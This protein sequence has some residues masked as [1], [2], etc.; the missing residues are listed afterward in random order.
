VVHQSTEEIGYWPQD[1]VSAYAC[2]LDELA[3]LRTSTFLVGAPG[4]GKTVLVQ[5]MAATRQFVEVER[6]ARREEN[7]EKEGLPMP[8]AQGPGKVV[9]LPVNALTLTELYGTPDESQDNDD[10]DHKHGKKSKKHGDDDSSV[11]LVPAGAKDGASTGGGGDDSASVVTAASTQKKAP[12]PKAKRLEP[13]DPGM[14]SKVLREISLA[15]KKNGRPTMLVLDGDCASGGGWAEVMVGLLD[16]ADARPEAPPRMAFLDNLSLRLPSNLNLVLEVSQLRSATPA[17]VSRCGLLFVD[18]SDGFAWRCCMANWVKALPDEVYS[19]V[20]KEW[21]S[22]FLEAYVP[23]CLRWTQKARAT[24]A[25]WGSGGGSYACHPTAMALVNGLLR[26]LG[27]LIDEHPQMLRKQNH[28][29]V[30]FM[31]CCCWAMGG[32]LPRAGSDL[33][34]G[35]GAF[36]A[37][38]GKSRGGGGGAGGGSSGGPNGTYTASAFSEW[39]RNEF[40][41]TV[42][43]RGG[44]IFD[45]WLDPTTVTFS[46]WS[47]SAYVLEPFTAL[48]DDFDPRARHYGT[49]SEVV[50]PTGDGAATAYWLRRLLRAK[51]PVLVASGPGGASGKRR[52]FTEAFQLMS[53]PALTAADLALG[54]AAL[55]T[56]VKLLRA[57]SPPKWSTCTVPLHGSISVSGL[58]AQVRSSLFLSGPGSLT[59][60]IG[61]ENV[62]VFVED[63]SLASCGS[64]AVLRRLAETSQVFGE[65]PQLHSL[66][67]S[68]VA[69]AATTSLRTTPSGAWGPTSGT[70]GG[71][72]ISSRGHLLAPGLGVGDSGLGLGDRG[73]AA[74]EAARLQRHFTIL[75]KGPPGPA[76]LQR[77]CQ[78]LLVLHVT[79]NADFPRLLKD[80]AEPLAKIIVAT[81]LELCAKLRRTPNKPFLSFNLRSLQRIMDGG[82]LRT[83]PESCYTVE[84][85]VSAYVHEAI[86][87]YGDCCNDPHDVIKVEK[88]LSQQLKEKFPNVDLNKHF[89][90]A[91]P[92]EPLIF[93]TCEDRLKNRGSELDYDEPRLRA[94]P[95]SYDATRSQMEQQL[96]RYPLTPEA[97]AAAEGPEGFEPKRIR[98]DQRAP[99]PPTTVRLV[100]SSLF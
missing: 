18:D 54:S 26:L 34:G 33:G 44:T 95:V 78:T 84:G 22:G 100:T 48:K 89:P 17:L 58:Q 86:R 36:A 98:F 57:T 62:M 77:I 53:A 72:R 59:P 63:L 31:F 32:H 37:P 79:K 10:D 93:S 47:R 28:L 46:E 29:E 20:A 82:M 65:S 9:V 61:T 7:A 12:V 3:T 99:S 13:A 60:P 49:M 96:R 97:L 15:A 68:G 92:T 80:N 71:G 21:I 55:A 6:Q 51:H 90:L 42:F 24:G 40:K 8:A 23:P 52:A 73:E 14:L 91:K 25:G 87:T 2:Q 69:L 85:M 19:D 5:V 45:W 27:D 56:K 70:S 30:A 38:A 88:V 41:T 94:V 50:V 66:T 75:W 1:Q 43:P 16:Q 35:S 11:A 81:H 64:A 83:N 74:G 4:A 76:D 67:V 39:W